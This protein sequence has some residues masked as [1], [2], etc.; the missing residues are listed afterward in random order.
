MLGPWMPAYG[1]KEAAASQRALV[2]DTGVGFCF[3]FYDT[4]FTDAYM[5]VC[6][7]P[8]RRFISYVCYL[9]FLSE[10]H[11]KAESNAFFNLPPP[12]QDAPV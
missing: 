9:A 4:P 6:R 2:K 1:I 5:L 10:L 8:A 3:Q 12:V 11:V 7:E